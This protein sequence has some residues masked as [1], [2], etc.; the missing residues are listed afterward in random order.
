VFQIK[1]F[2]ASFALMAGMVKILR[3]EIAQTGCGEVSL[4]HIIRS[5]LRWKELTTQTTGILKK[6]HNMPRSMARHVH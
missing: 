5:F 6:E 2:Y 4:R 1:F 3:L